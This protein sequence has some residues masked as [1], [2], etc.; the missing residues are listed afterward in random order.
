MQKVVSDYNDYKND[1]KQ[2]LD[3]YYQPK[4][5]ALSKKYPIL[6]LPI[7]WVKKRV[8]DVKNNFNKEISTKFEPNFF[9]SIL[10][11]HQSLLYRKLGNSKPELNDG[12]VQNLRVAIKSLDGIVIE[13]GKIFS[14]WKHLGD[15][16]TQRGYANGMLLS[17]GK[18]VEGVGGGLCQLSN[19]IYWMFLHTDH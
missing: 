11:R 14:L 13:P 3:D 6:R 1:I 18:I 7:I 10:V 17:N 9:P 4:R 19:L 8:V 15:P 16:T 12:K 5:T 2:Q